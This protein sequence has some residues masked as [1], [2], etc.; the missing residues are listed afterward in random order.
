[1]RTLKWIPFGFVSVGIFLGDSAIPLSKI[2]PWIQDAL[3]SLEYITGPATSKWGSVRAA[4]GHPDP[5]D[6][7]IVA[8]GNEN[9]CSFDKNHIYVEYYNTFAPRIRAAYPNIRFIANCDISATAKY[10]DI[11]DYHVYSSTQWFLQNVGLF[12]KQDRKGPSVFVSEYAVTQDC[13]NGNLQ[14]AVA[15]AAFMTGLVRNSDIVELAS[16]APLF[17]HVNDRRWNPDIIQFDNHRTAPTPSYYVQQ[18][19]SKYTGNKV[20]DHTVRNGNINFAVA[21]TY[22]TSKKLVYV[23]VVNFS[24]NSVTADISISGANVLT[25]GVV[26]V[27]TSPSGNPKDENSLTNPKLVAITTYNITISPKFSFK[28]APYSVSIL[29][30]PTK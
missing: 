8:L 29:Q 15:E 23:P 27:L 14:A 21:T 20:V 11:F 18:L 12:D 25:E 4:S 10:V 28:A 5:F 17:V 3:D 19:F 13:G 2:E 24:P 6:L 16:Y 9:G 26:Y 30:I 22:D 7:K 1:V